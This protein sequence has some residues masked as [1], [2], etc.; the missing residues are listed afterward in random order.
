MKRAVVYVRQSRHHDLERTVSPQVQRETCLALPAVQACAEVEVLEDLDASGKSTVGRK[1]FQTL[2]DRVKSRQLNVV[3]IYD[4]SR[5][6]RSTRDAL[7]FNVL[8]ESHPEIEVR[9]VHGQ[10][11][12]SPAGEFTYTA[13]AAAHAMERRMV[14]EKMRDAVRYRQSLGDMVGAVPAGYR[15]ASDGSVSVDEA[16][17]L[18]VRNLFADFA[19]GGHSV[20]NLAHDLNLRGE[21]LPRGRTAWRGDTVAQLLGNV[22]Y[23]GRTYTQSRRYRRGLLIEA[24]WPAL[25]SAELFDTV[26]VQL[27]ARQ[28]FGSSGAAKTTT[29][30]GYIFAGLLR[31]SCGRKMRGQA[32]HAS[33]SY[34]CPGSDAAI[35]C[36]HV[37]GEQAIV[38]WTEEF[39][40]LEGSKN[41]STGVRSG[42]SSEE[43]AVARVEAAMARQGRRFQWGHVNERSYRRE[44]DR[45]VAV[46]VRL[47]GSRGGE[48]RSTPRVANVVRR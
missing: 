27:R 33:L 4:Q 45:L 35:P 11:D 32:D 31:C 14:A 1:G 6:F 46:R 20:A 3:A 44:W 30:R 36:R 16:T 42:T 12:R 38:A 29:K 40:E 25:I 19:T 8:V 26:Q 7:E 24:N 34:R 43:R 22:A 41:R 15:R 28:R 5:A 9:F 39:F 17:A 48:R 47:E 2:V 10:F 23:A 13:L 18:V 37:V 21:R